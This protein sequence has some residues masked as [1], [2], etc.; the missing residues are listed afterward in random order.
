MKFEF[1]VYL[2]R[3]YGESCKTQLNIKTTGE[4]DS[5]DYYYDVTSL[6]ENI[7]FYEMEKPLSYLVN[8]ISSDFYDDV[9]EQ[10]DKLDEEL[11]VDDDDFYYCCLLF[12]TMRKGEDIIQEVV[13]T[14]DDFFD[15]LEEE[16]K[17]IKESMF[18]DDY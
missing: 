17:D 16:I 11:D 1:E 14:L 7:V 9:L 3:K 15:V 12:D 4:E 8:S 13:G 2:I 6:L 10:L 5:I 18:D